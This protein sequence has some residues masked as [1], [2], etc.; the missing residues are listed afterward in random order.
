MK[1]YGLDWIGTIPGIASTHDLSRK[2]RTGFILRILASVFWIAFGIVAETP[3]GVFVSFASRLI[4]RHCRNCQRRHCLQ[5]GALDLDR[6]FSRNER[7]RFR[8]PCA[9]SQKGPGNYGAILID[10]SGRHVK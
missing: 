6:I 1:C 3:A 8:R 9:H 4:R 5:I 2:S 10:D 7:N